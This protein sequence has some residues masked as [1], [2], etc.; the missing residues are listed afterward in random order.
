MTTGAQKYRLTWEVGSGYSN[1][2]AAE[3]IEYTMSIN[4]DFSNSAG[5]VFHINDWEIDA[6]KCEA[7]VD[8]Y[9][10]T[11]WGGQDLCFIFSGLPEVVG[12]RS[13]L[14]F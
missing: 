7:I 13:E 12:P 1:Q 5:Q 4:R 2:D 11:E 14:M 8:L 6:D 10:Y 9:E 3:R